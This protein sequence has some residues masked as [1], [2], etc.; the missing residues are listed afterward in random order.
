MCLT[1]DKREG[2]YKL[3]IVAE[4]DE[5]IRYRPWIRSIGI[6]YSG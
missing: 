1:H 5:E 6:L 2:K 4:L 3:I